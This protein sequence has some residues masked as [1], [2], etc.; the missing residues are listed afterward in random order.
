MNTSKKKL[1]NALKDM[2]AYVIN[3]FKEE[4]KDN[5]EDEEDSF[6]DV[7]DSEFT[8]G[9]DLHYKSVNICLCF[10]GPTILLDTSCARLIGYWGFEEE[11]LPIP[12]DICDEID[13]YFENYYNCTK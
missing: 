5:E 10:G 12:Y 3:S 1:F 4:R 13:D 9:S 6:Y 2:Q 7:L 8:V 11:S